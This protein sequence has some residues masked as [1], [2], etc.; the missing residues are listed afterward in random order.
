MPRWWSSYQPLPTITVE[1]H[2]D[3]VIG[4]EIY[5]FYTNNKEKCV[6]GE[7]LLASAILSIPKYHLP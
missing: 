7:D 3:N 6:I 4:G 2:F 1:D 5:I